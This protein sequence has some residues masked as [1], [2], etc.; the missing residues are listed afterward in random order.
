MSMTTTASTQKT[1]SGAFLVI[2]GSI[3]FG[4]LGTVSVMAYQQGMAPPAFAAWRETIGAVGLLLIL[5]FGIGRPREGGGFSWSA[6][7]M[8]QKVRLG[9]AALAFMT[10]SLAIFYAF[11][12]ITVALTLLIFY[13]YPALVTLVSGITGKERFT[14][15]KVIALL[16]AL[17]GSLLAIMGGYFT[18]GDMQINLLGVS[19]AALAAIADT[20][21]FLVGR[22]GYPDVPPIYATTSFLVAGA[23]VFALISLAAG[24]VESL[25]YPFAHPDVFP[26]LLFAGIFGAAVP[27]IMILAGIRMV[28]SSRASILALTEPAAGVVFAA[29]LLSQTMLPIQMVGGVL[30]IVALVLLQ[31][32]PDKGAA[33]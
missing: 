31:L 19:L 17:A 11:N 7:P 26:I 18:A 13:L 8:Q 14:V 6:L 4:T 25:M 33:K 2:V 29:L 3:L 27:T 20:V 9:I 16:M 30:V 23:V 24:G 32:F 21:Y 12:L 5:S 1:A 15:S 22:D 28:G 10:F